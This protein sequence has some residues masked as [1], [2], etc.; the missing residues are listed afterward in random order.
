M[1]LILNCFPHG[2]SEGSLSLQLYLWGFAEAVRVG[3]S[4]VMWCVFERH[5]DCMRRLHSLE[6]HTTWSTIRM[7]APILTPRITC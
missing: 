1:R 7:H 3:V 2:R 6:A 5:L 4:F